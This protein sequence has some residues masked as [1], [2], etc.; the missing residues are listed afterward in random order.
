MKIISKRTI[1]YR[2]EYFLEWD[3]PEGSG[4]SFPCDEYGVV[5]PHNISTLGLE[6][7]R[8]CLNGKMEEYVGPKVNKR[9]YRDKTPAIGRCEC[10]I[11]VTLSYNTNK[12]WKCGVLYNLFGQR[13][14]HAIPHDEMEG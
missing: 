3:G 10:G 2:V 9:Q 5:T 4:Y 8:D 7:L 1:D 12:C 6:N 11:E 14:D 13:V